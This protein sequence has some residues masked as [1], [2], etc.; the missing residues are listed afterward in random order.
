M[1][2]SYNTGVLHIV[3]HAILL[4][5]AT[6][7]WE[8]LGIDKLSQFI[9]MLT[10]LII[11][12]WITFFPFFFLLVGTYVYVMRNEGSIAWW[13][14]PD[15]GN[16]VY[17]LLSRLLFGDGC[18]SI[19]VAWECMGVRL[20]VCGVL[21]RETR[22]TAT[23]EWAWRP[24]DGD[25]LWMMELP[26][27]AESV[28]RTV[29]RCGEGGLEEEEKKRSWGKKHLWLG[30][31]WIRGTRMIPLRLVSDQAVSAEGWEQEEE[32]RSCLFC[33]ASDEGEACAFGRCT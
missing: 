21:N 16:W 30:G 13:T 27:W 20:D 22:L 32:G 15:S 5:L 29:D 8:F 24:N 17:T 14:S 4:F 26:L 3:Y 19:N 6:Q 25:T 28:W 10:S 31:A 33:E 1:L 7:D 11:T 18:L 12:P 2:C 9:L 23:I